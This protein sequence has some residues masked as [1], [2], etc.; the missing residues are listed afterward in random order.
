MATWYD[1]VN[2]FCLVI[3]IFQLLRYVLPW[4]YRNFIGPNIFS[5]DFKRFGTWAIITGATDGIGKEYAKQLARRGLNVV[6]ISRSQLK[7]QKTAEELEKE[8][9]VQVKHICVDFKRPNEIY[10]NVEQQIA[11]L[12]V[13]VLVNNV[14]LSYANPEFFL[15][16]P[17]HDEFVSNV[18]S[19]NIIS[20]LQM[21]KLVLAG[22]VSRK[23]GLIINISSL[24]AHIPSPLLTVYAASKVI[25]GSASET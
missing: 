2:I 10:E 3:V 25:V 9:K 4:I 24:A 13:G 5:V 1:I 16:I 18:I 23:R 11:S 21:T 15:T 19:C 8:F 14:G 7:L 12:D 6:L 22:M 17:G 20:T